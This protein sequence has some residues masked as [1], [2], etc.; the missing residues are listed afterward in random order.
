M[1]IS[2]QERGKKHSPIIKSVFPPLCL[3]APYSAIKLNLTRIKGSD[4][5]SSYNNLT[6]HCLPAELQWLS[7][8]V[9]LIHGKYKAIWLILK[10]L[11]FEKCLKYGCVHVKEKRQYLYLVPNNQKNEL[12]INMMCVYIIQILHVL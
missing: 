9:L 7:V 5:P 11:H 1:G 4:I 10:L 6:S 8:C 3:L 2:G 12:W